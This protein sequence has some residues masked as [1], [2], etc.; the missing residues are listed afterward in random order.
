MWHHS[1]APAPTGLPTDRRPRTIVLPP[2]IVRP[3]L[4]TVAAEAIAGISDEVASSFWAPLD[5]IFDP[6]SARSTEIFVRD[7]SMMVPAIHFEGRVIWGMTE[8]ILR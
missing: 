7:T 2:V 8:R 3:F 1:P 6:A 4:A 5:V